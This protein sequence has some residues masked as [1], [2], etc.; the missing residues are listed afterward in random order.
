VL[1]FEI[2]CLHCS[3]FL[4]SD[5]NLQT[6]HLYTAA[7]V[8]ELDRL[9]IDVAGISGYTLM[10]RAGEACWAVLRK[11][12]P[13]ARSLTVLCGAGN[14]G[15]DGFVIARLALAANWQVRLYQLGNTSHMQAD[16]RQ[17]CDAFTRTGGQVQPFT[18]ATAIEGDVIVDA[19]L[20]TGVDRP[21]QGLWRNAIDAINA[22]SAPVL[23]VDIPSGVQADSGTVAGVAAHADRTVT[24]IGRKAGLYTGAAPDYSGRISFADLGV[25]GSIFEQVPVA[26]TLLRQ[27]AL[28][29]LAQPRLRTAH[30]GHYGHVLV[31]GGNYGM[32]GAARLAGEAALRSG[33][34]RVSLATRPDHAAL[35]AAACPELMCH[36]VASAQALKALL[37]SA[38][39]VLIGPGLGRSAW[40][41][42]LLSAVLETS[43][44]RVIDADA[45][46]CL[47]VEAL[48]FEQQVLTP[49]PGEAARLLGQSVLAV[50]ADRY[51]AAREIAS[52]YGGTTV[53]KGAGTVIQPA[54]DR[55]LVCAAG[56]P[57]MATAGSGDV[58]AGVISALIAQGMDTAAA[59]AAGVCAHACAGDVAAR[60]G[61]RGL[62]ARDLIAALRPVLNAGRDTP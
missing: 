28:G 17:A 27:P 42:S 11:Q 37:P 12:W 32:V 60:A 21:L 9:A 4:M 46:H 35:I 23:A 20:G 25:P 6:H 57:G 61:E 33:A 54:G 14:N 62:I 49:H 10:C 44:P 15:G 19:L 36:G 16:A 40:A 56:N 29:A 26:A 7:Q 30:K 31:I 1:R 3:D 38:G 22:A 55:P 41:Q 5:T 52:R 59:A 48:Y 47:A 51:A 8:R 43:I 45:L 50:Q 2:A 18:A 24:F 34:G 58:L 39:V 13:A 53:L